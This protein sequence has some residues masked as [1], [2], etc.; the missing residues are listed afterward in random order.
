[1]NTDNH[2]NLY[3]YDVYFIRGMNGIN[4]K[5]QNLPRQAVRKVSRYQRDNQK[6]KSKKD[7]QCKVFCVVFCR[8]LFVLLC[9]FFLPLCFLYFG[10]F[11]LFFTRYLQSNDI[12]KVNILNVGG[13]K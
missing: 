3:M 7:R 10:F 12:F 4:N 9:F 13:S 5:L 11:K 2:I 8:S 1:M 6:S